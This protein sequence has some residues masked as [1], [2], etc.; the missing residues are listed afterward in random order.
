M[1]RGE[2]GQKSG[3][4]RERKRKKREM[5]REGVGRRWGRETETG[6]RSE[7][8]IDFQRVAPSGILNTE[9]LIFGA[10]RNIH[11]EGCGNCSI[12]LDKLSF[13]Q[14]LLPICGRAARLQKAALSP[15][16]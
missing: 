9:Q 2:G 6:M 3:R 4:E 12:R 13:Y 1:G 7:D 8:T 5:E 16:P 11:P 14:T 10:H 15:L